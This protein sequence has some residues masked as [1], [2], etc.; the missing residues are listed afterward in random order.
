MKPNDFFT[1]NF[2]GAGSGDSKKIDNLSNRYHYNEPISYFKEEFGG[3]SG[4]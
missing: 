1:N 4:K 2:S 3:M